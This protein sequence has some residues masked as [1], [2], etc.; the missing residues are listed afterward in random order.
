MPTYY[1][2]F[3]L[4]GK[5]TVKIEAVNGEEALKIAKDAVDVPNGSPSGLKLE[6]FWRIYDEPRLVD[7]FS[8]KVRKQSEAFRNFRE[9]LEKNLAQ[10]HQRESIS[11]P[12]EQPS[13]ENQHTYYFSVPFSGQAVVEIKARDEDQARISARSAATSIG[14]RPIEPPFV[15]YSIQR[16]E[17]IMVRSDLT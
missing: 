11:P 8:T 14:M 7:D 12:P 3:A 10:K 5:K 9:E 16:S 1:V 6:S 4:T 2:E 13:A 17:P 15:T